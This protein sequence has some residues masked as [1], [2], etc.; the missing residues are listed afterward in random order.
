[1]AT[2][3]QAT[4]GQVNRLA[5]KYENDQAEFV[6]LV[7]KLRQR[8][9][10]LE[11]EMKGETV[12]R[13]QDAGIYEVRIAELAEQLEGSTQQFD[14]IKRV[15]SEQLEKIKQL[16][17]GLEKAEAT[18]WETIRLVQ[19]LQQQLELKDTQITLLTEQFRGALSRSEELQKL[20]V[21]MGKDHRDQLAKNTE[22]L[23]R[24]NRN[25]E[26]RVTPVQHQGP[27][28]GGVAAAAVN[29]LVSAVASWFFCKPKV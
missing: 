7:K 25:L 16:S 9:H 17:A 21:Q 3:V 27:T 15:A 2:A 22:A 29:G 10:G 24:T 28:V 11:Q 14:A 12:K 20:I 1:M 23:N 26:Q 8:I 19:S 5:E 18:G 13:L 4:L 6:E